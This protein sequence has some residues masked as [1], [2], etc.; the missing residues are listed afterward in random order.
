[1]C[2]LASASSIDVYEITV[3]S[4]GGLRLSENFTT[5]FRVE[6]LQR[7]CPAAR[8]HTFIT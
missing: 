2:A 3:L 8:A 6:R 1:M 4:T 7:P 5:S